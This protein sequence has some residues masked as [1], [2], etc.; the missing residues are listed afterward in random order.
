MNNKIIFGQYYDADSLLHRLDP[1]TKLIGLLFMVIS[2]FII[3]NIYTL[4][5]FTLLLLILI[6]LTKAPVAKFFRSLRAMSY[7]MIFTFIIQVLTNQKIDDVIVAKPLFNLTYMNLGIILVVLILWVL[8]S[9]YI[10][11]F[12]IPIFILLLAMAFVLQHYVNITPKIVSYSITFTETG[13][14]KGSF[15]VIRIIDFLLISSILTLTTKPTQINCALEKLLKPLA[16]MGLNVGAFSMIISITL[17]FIP[18]LLQ[19]ASKV[20]KAQASR[21]ADFNDAKLLSKVLQMTSLVIPLF[22]ITYKKAS[23][24]SYAMEA[25][26]YV[27]KKDRSSLYVLEYRFIDYFSIVFIFALFVFSIISRIIL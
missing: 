2:L 10:K 9:K 27:E 24:L 25:R 16:K 17:R 6:L 5:G 7:I 8:F 1:R 26:G 15:L 19:E 20:L 4:L 21:G 23:D 18:T 12:K 11:F 14:I 22:I 3:N 13:L